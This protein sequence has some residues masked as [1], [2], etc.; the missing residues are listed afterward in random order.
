MMSMRNTHDRTAVVVGAG[1]GGLAAAVALHR[2]GWQVT[3]LERQPALGA[4]GAGIA[5]A[6]NALRA[7]DVLEVGQAVRALAAVQGAAGYRTPDGRWLLR[8]DFA[9]AARRLGDPFVVLPRAKL[10][11]L[12]VQQ[13]P[14]ETL[15][16]DT[17]VTTIDPGDEAR[18]AVVT[19]GEKQWEADVVVAADGIASSIRSRLFP[20]HPELRYAGYT[21]WRLLPRVAPEVASAGQFETWGAGQR[22]S[23]LP[24]HDGQVYCWA[25]ATTPPRGKAED[26]RAEL[27]SRFRTWHNPIPALIEATDPTAV[28]RHDAMELARPLPAMHAGRIAMLGDAAHAMTPDL[29]Q[30]ACQGIED[31]VVLAHHL[32][33]LKTDVTT[34]LGSYTAERLPR[35]SRIAV[36]SRQMARLGQAQRKPAVV[37][38]DQ[39]LT[40]ASHLPATVILGSLTST[41]GW[42]PPQP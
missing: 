9:E 7:L 29:G 14:A 22:F 23:A 38:R 36:A 24:M 39:L 12:L 18:P 28:L 16:L 31:A 6:P 21:A 35:T 37:M 1:I 3:V 8:M 27:L 33:N 2:T 15:Q 5:I 11:A 13:L 32:K 25:T 26:E 34:A 30:G 20:D 17:K 10:I 4:V 19:A 42:R 40:A 41:V